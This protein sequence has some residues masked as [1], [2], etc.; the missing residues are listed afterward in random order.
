MSTSNLSHQTL[1]EVREQA[2]RYV[3]GYVSSVDALAAIDRV[4]GHPFVGDSLNVAHAAFDREV[5]ARID[6]DAR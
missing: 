5:S 1:A 2:T 6:A 3:R 4:A